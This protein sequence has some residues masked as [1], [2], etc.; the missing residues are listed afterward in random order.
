MRKQ[1]SSKFSS[2]VRFEKEDLQAICRCGHEGAGTGY[3]SA[4]I[5]AVMDLSGQSS[6]RLLSSC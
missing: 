5:V 4:G 6:I 3:C 1:G 2:L